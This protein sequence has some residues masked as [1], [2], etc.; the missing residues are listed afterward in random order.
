MPYLQ[1]KL[2]MKEKST[3]LRK[4]ISGLEISGLEEEN[5]RLW[6]EILKLEAKN[7]Q[8]TRKL[9]MMESRLMMV[10]ERDIIYI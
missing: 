7:H 4:E 3:G 6:K 10:R 2:Q 8:L 9:S 5:V 1:M